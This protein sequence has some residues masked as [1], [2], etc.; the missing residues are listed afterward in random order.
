MPSNLFSS[1]E[2]NRAFQKKK[3]KKNDGS[4]LCQRK[5]LD[6]GAV[7]LNR[8]HLSPLLYC[9]YKMCIT[10]KNSEQIIPI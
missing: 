3:K 8:Q 7:A 6:R 4:T 2:D 10:L 5:R 1:E 9:H